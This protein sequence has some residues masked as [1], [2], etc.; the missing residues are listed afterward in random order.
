MPDS[1]LVKRGERVL[2]E[3]HNGLVKLAESITLQRGPLKGR[4][5]ANGF[6]PHID[7]PPASGAVDHAFKIALSDGPRGELLCRFTPGHVGGIIPIIGVRYLDDFDDEDLGPALEIPDD[8]WKK[9]GLTERALIMFR[10]E[11]N[12][13]FA[14]AKVVPVAVAAPPDN[15]PFAWHKL[16]AILIRS[17][18]G[19]IRVLQQCFFSQYFDTSERKPSGRFRAWP[20]AAS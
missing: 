20:R 12:P 3:H 11:L 15:P 16:I 1:L 18:D 13:S 6:T 9:R 19:A 10:Y 7:V 8:A 4:Q 2:A 17:E 5:D 14:V